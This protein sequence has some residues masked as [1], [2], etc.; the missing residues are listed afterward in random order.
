[1]VAFAGGATEFLYRMLRK[2]AAYSLSEVR[3][4]ASVSSSKI[5]KR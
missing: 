4:Y 5:G 3:R 1:L 2:A